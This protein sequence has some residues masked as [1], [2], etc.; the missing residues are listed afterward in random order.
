MCL[1]QGLLQEAPEHL[2][3][4]EASL[5]PE[6]AHTPCTMSNPSGSF[7][8]QIVYICYSDIYPTVT[9]KPEMPGNR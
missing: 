3:L 2:G 4:Q 1:G 5:P 8:S 9:L 6:E 7:A